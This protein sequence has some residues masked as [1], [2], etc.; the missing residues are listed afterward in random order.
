MEKAGGEP[1]GTPE[2]SRSKVGRPRPV[3]LSHLI[4]PENVEI[5]TREHP[6]ERAS[7]LRREEA[8]AE[9]Q[10]KKDFVLFIIVAIMVC[11][12]ALACLW[13]NL[14]SNYSPDLQKWASSLLTVIVSA[15]LGYMTGKSSKP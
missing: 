9:H 11:L 10:R 12:V 3:N 15:I 5:K 7:R 1:S 2:E 4:D 13:I 8:D 6:E 14:S